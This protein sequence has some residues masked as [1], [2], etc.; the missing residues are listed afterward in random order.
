LAATLDTDSI[1][2]GLICGSRIANYE[3]QT[4]LWCIDEPQN[5]F[6]LAQ[7]TNLTF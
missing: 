5:G 2:A 6:M 3:P 7:Y 4:D 1:M